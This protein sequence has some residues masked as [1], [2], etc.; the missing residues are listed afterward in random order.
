LN[1]CSR[2]S[3]PSP[4]SKRSTLV[5]QR[6]TSNGRL[7]VKSHLINVP[8]GRNASF[9]S[10]HSEA[11]G[12]GFP[13]KRLLSPTLSSFL[14]QE[15]RET[16]SA[17]GIYERR[18]KRCRLK[19]EVRDPKSVAGLV[20]PCDCFSSRQFAKFASTGPRRSRAQRAQRTRMVRKVNEVF[21]K[22]ELLRARCPRSLGI[23]PAHGGIRVIRG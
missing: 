5:V 13:Q 12:E 3:S 20:T 7:D 2:P 19:P 11:W 22:P 1:P 10:P 15:E 4:K 6:S 23:R 9:P 18:S 21:S 8:P 14:R 17:V 16:N